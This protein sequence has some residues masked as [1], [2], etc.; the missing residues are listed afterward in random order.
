MH[1]PKKYLQTFDKVVQEPLGLLLKNNLNY[2]P[3][4]ICSGAEISIATKEQAN[5]PKFIDRIY[6]AWLIRCLQK[7]KVFVPKYLNGFKLLSMLIKGN[8]VYKEKG[9]E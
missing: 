7:L 9:M 1:I 4:I 8:I 5:I 2:K 6:L 3:G